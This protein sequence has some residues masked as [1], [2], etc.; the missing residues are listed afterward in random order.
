[1]TFIK[2]STLYNIRLSNLI[3]I[4]Q[5]DGIFSNLLIL[6]LSSIQQVISGYANIF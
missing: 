6:I 4:V 2:R 5:I 1:M 3:N